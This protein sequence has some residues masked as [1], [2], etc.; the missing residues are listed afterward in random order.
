LIDVISRNY[1]I[2]CRCGFLLGIQCDN[3]VRF[4][5]PMLAKSH[6]A[7]AAQQRQQY[8][9]ITCIISIKATHFV[10]VTFSSSV[11]GEALTGDE[12]A[13]ANHTPAR[14]PT[15]WHLM[16]EAKLDQQPFTPST[17]PGCSPPAPVCHLVPSS[18]AL[19]LLSTLSCQAIHA[20]HSRIYFYVLCDSNYRQE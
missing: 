7:Y 18:L 11:I 4:N 5:D 6:Y 14:K 1:R 20:V 2:D 8:R 15:S 16:K 12:Q 19:T 17:T 10:C 13:V 3:E 9:A